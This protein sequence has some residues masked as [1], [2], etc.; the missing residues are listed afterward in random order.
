MD[1]FS[2]SLSSPSSSALDDDFFAPDPSPSSPDPLVLV[3]F[4]WWYE[5]NVGLGGK[6]EIGGVL[7]DVTSRLSKKDLF[8]S[9][10]FLEMRSL[11][12]AGPRCEE[13]AGL[14]SS[15][16]SNSNGD[17]CLALIAEWMFTRAFKWHN[18]MK[19][20]EGFLAPSDSIDLFS[21]QIRVSFSHEMNSLYLRINQKD[22]DRRAFDR[23]CKIF[24]SESELLQLWDIQGQT[25]QFIKNKSRLSCVS[26]QPLDEVLL[27]LEVYGTSFLKDREIERHNFTTEQ[28]SVPSPSGHHKMNGV[29]HGLDSLSQF[30]QYDV[31]DGM[32]NSAC[33]LGFTGL[34]NLGNTCFMNS[35]LQ[36][37]VHTM[38]LVGYFLDDFHKDLNVENPL[39]MSGKLAMA[40]G[41]LLRKLWAPGATPVAPRMFKSVI[42]GF[43]P[44][45]G[46]YNQHDAQEFLAFLLDGLH[47]DL[48]RVKHKPYIEVRDGDGCPDDEVADEHW[49]NHL[50]RNNSVIVDLFQGQYRSTLVC[51]VCGKLSITFDPFMYLSLPLPST[52]T[53]TMT[54]I[55]FNTEGT[56]LPSPVTISVPKFGTSRDLVQALSRACSLKDDETLL[57]AEVYDNC[58]LRFLDDPSDAIELIRDDDRLVAYH[59]P[60]LKEGYPVVIFTH[61][62]EKSQKKFGFPLV[63]RISSPVKGSDVH[64][65]FFKLLRPFSVAAEGPS[66]DEG[67]KGNSVD[68]DAEV[69]KAMLHEGAELSEQSDGES[70]KVSDF[71]FFL[72]GNCIHDLPMNEL[73]PGQP[74]RLDVSVSWSDKMIDYY[75]TTL[76]NFLPEVCKPT[77]FSKKP[78]ES[79]SLDRCLNAFLKEESLGPE[80]MW[81]CPT[82]KT[83]QQANKK[84][85]LWRLPKIL[86]IHLKRFSYNR[87]LKN[88]LETFVDFPV[89]DFDISNYMVYQDK[90]ISHRYKL[91][92]VSNHIGGIGSGHYTAFIYHRKNM[93]FEFDDSNVF[94]MNEDQIKS[95]SA[96][97]LFYR[98]ISDAVSN[99]EK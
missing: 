12:E 56:T 86:I 17:K 31:S 76:M 64:N 48:N 54:L 57:V 87:F 29:A 20:S 41:D 30:K 59:M 3:P 49:R 67:G 33:A 44:Q 19:D 37:M 11:N 61:R 32:Y 46:G 26:E 8:D 28:F 82:C 23:A 72:H 96:Y 21:L 93:W 6:S 75:D 38:E 68:E 94:P 79:V 50:A 92:A 2:F 13:E 71:Q 34:Y 18:D 97:V 24:C 98:R 9:D 89:D 45:F 27:K 62:E 14:L 47:E 4:R 39:G 83:H 36:C 80:D 43:A 35:A 90:S 95:S 1:P 52:S 5:A 10:I 85:D 99:I 7:Y 25:T 84:L 58:I 69:E 81:Y 78:R 63:S 77:L 15:S 88:K 51:P 40:F 60:K 42:A 16:R 66:N 73:I 55:V 65:E 91:Y 74:A 22:N 70:A 53:R